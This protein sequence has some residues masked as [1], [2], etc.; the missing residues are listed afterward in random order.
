M[1]GSRI[2]TR[3]VAPTMGVCHRANYGR[4]APVQYESELEPE[5]GLEGSEVDLGCLCWHLATQAPLNQG[6]CRERRVTGAVATSGRPPAR[7]QARTLLDQA[8]TE[9]VGQGRRATTPC[10]SSATRDQT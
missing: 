2:Q 10:N 6:S 8:I 5:A 7:T 1:R 3:D 9:T 4:G